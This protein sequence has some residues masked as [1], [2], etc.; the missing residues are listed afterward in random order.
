MEPLVPNF[1]FVGVVAPSMAQIYNSKT[2]VF[3]S[4]SIG[5]TAVVSLATVTSAH[6]TKSSKSALGP[7][8]AVTSSQAASAIG[9]R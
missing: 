2:R 7:Q 1:D 5:F 3:S 6:R 4:T 8:V 9:S